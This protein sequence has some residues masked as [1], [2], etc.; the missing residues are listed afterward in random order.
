MVNL[1]KK[2]YNFSRFQRGSNI[3][4]GGQLCLLSIETHITC[5]FSGGG[6]PD[7]CP[8]PPLDPHLTVIEYVVVFFLSF[9]LILAVG[10]NL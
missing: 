4:E 6:G 8:H 3:V 9:M 7:P 10:Q 2:I 5:D 1:K